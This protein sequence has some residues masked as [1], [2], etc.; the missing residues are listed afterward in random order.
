MNSRFV[1]RRIYDRLHE[2]LDLTLPEGEQ[3][4]CTYSH[5][6]L[7]REAANRMQNEDEIDG[8]RIDAG[9]GN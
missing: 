3:V 2:V 7:A 1:I 5:P 6:D 8:G 9:Q 4:V